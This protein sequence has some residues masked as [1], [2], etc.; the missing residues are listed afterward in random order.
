MCGI[1]GIYNLNGKP[2]EERLL[3]KMAG[4]MKHR[5]PDD[6]GYYLDRNIGLAH[7]RLSIIDLSP[8]GHQ[9]MSN[10]D[11][12]IW[13]VHNGEIYN[14]LELKEELKA[15]GYLFKTHTD[16]EVIIYAYQEWGENCLGRFN[17][18]WA[19]AIWD[20]KEKKLFCSRDRFGVKPF[21]YYFNGT[22]FIFASEIKALLLH[23]DI[24]KEVNEGVIYD[25]LTLGLL[26]HTQETFFKGIS[27]LRPSHYLVLTESRGLKFQRYWDLKA[28]KTTEDFSTRISDIA[29]R[30]RELLY[31]SVR[32]RLR[33]DV[34]VGTCLSG[35][36]DSSS[37]VCMANELMFKDRVIVPEIIGRQQKTFTSCFEDRRFDERKFAEA[38]IKKT[39]AEKNFVFPDGNK[40]WEELPSLV[41]H[42]DEPFGSTSIYAQWQVM[43]EAAQRGVKVLLDGQGGDEVLA[44]YLP[45]YYLTYLA[46]LLSGGKVLKAFSEAKKRSILSGAKMEIFLA[47]AGYN[48]IPFFLRKFIRDLRNIIFTGRESSALAALN[49]SFKIRFSERRSEYLKGRSNSLTNLS[50]ALYQDIFTYSLPSLL[51]YEDR[52]SMAFSLEA[53]TPFLDYRLVEYLFSLPA[54]LKIRDGLTKYVLREAMKGVLPEEVRLRKDK[55]GFVTPEIIWMRQG[56]ERIMALFSSPKVLSR[57]FV[58]PQFIAANLNALLS[59][60]E[61]GTTELWRWINLETWLNTFLR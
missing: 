57:D 45:Y 13:V 14:Y 23:P 48:I 1:A 4:A 54:S 37:I 60:R 51:H 34:P 18:M 8:A 39:G 50:E 3:Q 41:W 59:G 6:E 28:N 44:G 55:M 5:G 20:G 61:T 49:S 30:F 35:G 40:L 26:D 2:V 31:D 25:Y 19:L 22:V 10:E 9:P 7:K 15:K 12:S 43:R 58:N 11:K 47:H 38:I 36:I 29:T 33:S 27:Q 16:T 46:Q 24:S 53:R 21:Y 17:G 42:Q 32:L 52:N 56:R